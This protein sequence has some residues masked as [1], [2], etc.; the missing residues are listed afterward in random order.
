[1]C[2]CPVL[3]PRVTTPPDQPLPRPPAVLE[4]GRL[5]T[6]H[7]EA[8]RPVSDAVLPQELHGA[9]QHRARGLVVVEEV[10]S[11]KDE[12]HIVALRQLEYLLERV[13]RVLP[14]FGVFLSIANVVI[15]RCKR[16]DAHT[17]ICRGSQT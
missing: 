13:D 10:P 11:L 5:V 17:A 16:T 2:T 6:E 4:V 7:S 8:H 15:G 1:M 9:V 14:T 3:Y 12:I